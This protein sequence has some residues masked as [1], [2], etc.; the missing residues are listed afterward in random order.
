MKVIKKTII[1]GIL[2]LFPISIGIIS[3]VAIKKNTLEIPISQHENGRLQYAIRCLSCHGVNG[4][5]T[6]KGPALNDGI[7]I[8]GDG[9][10]PVIASIITNGTPTGQMKGWG[11]KLRKEDIYALSEFVYGLGAE[12]D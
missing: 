1:F 5:G 4:K 11:N 2:I 12:R 6:R 3:I 7:W 10:I 9:S 8:Y